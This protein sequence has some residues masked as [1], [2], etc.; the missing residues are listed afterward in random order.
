MEEMQFLTGTGDA[1]KRLDVYLSEE[2]A[3]LSRSYIQKLVE[4]DLI[5]VDGTVRKSSYRLKE[6]EVILLMLPEMETLEVT[7]KNIP[8]N[9]LYEDENLVV[10][11]KKKGMVVHPAIGNYTDT[12]VNALLYH[13]G[14]LSGINGVLR[15]GI[16]HRI[17]KDTTGILVVAKN[18][19]AHKVL[20]EQLK[21]HTMEREYLALVH[22]KV[23]LDEGT[24]SAPLARSKKDRMKITI[25]Q[26]GKEAVTHY[27]VLARYQ[28]FT[29]VRVR[30]ETGRTHQIRVHMASL[31]HPIVG[32]FVYGHLKKGP[33]KGQLLHANTL[34]FID[35]DGKKLRFTTPVH[36][37]FRKELMRLNSMGRV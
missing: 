30:L 36:E 5:T 7:P 31:H 28:G 4:K 16:V 23:K 21:A 9:I 12:L 37:E 2:M 32:D 8:L 11:D 18:D 1:G 6:E 22:G 29:L 25:D 15:P 24:I 26:D 17:D 19:Q 3:D 10:V 27:R 35:P 33:F 34:G 14:D 20:S 13:I